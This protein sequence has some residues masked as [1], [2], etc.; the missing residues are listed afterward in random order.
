MAN[1]SSGAFACARLRS[2]CRRILP[3]A[4][5]FGR[6]WRGPSKLLPYKANGQMVR[7]RALVARTEA[8]KAV[9][10]RH[11]EACAAQ[12]ALGEP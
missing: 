5:R 10:T 1:R 11:D 2:N 4:W 6:T 12:A 3:I 7:A 9:L 8:R